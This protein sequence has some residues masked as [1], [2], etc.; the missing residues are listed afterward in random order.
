MN[1]AWDRAF[2]DCI[3][4]AAGRRG[5]QHMRLGLTALT[6]LPWAQDIGHAPDLDTLRSTIAD[7]DEPLVVLDLPAGM[8]PPDL[9]SI[10]HAWA[11][12]RHTQQHSLATGEDPV[13]SWPHHRRKQWRRAER[14]GM[15]AERTQDV[16]LLVQLHQA[17]RQ[18]KGI[19][20]DGT[21]LQHLLNHL[22]QEPDTHA[23]L[24]R[25]QD[26]EPIAGGL[27]HGAGDG[28]CIYGFGGQFRGQKAGISS[29]A[30]VLLIGTAMRHAAGQ[31]SRVFD[32]GGSQ[33]PGVDRF[34]AE[35]GA[36]AI[37]KWRA[38]RIRGVWRP[39]LRW[40]RPDLFPA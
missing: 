12:K 11:V 9:A 33:D 35:F 2:P 16:N 40:R 6:T 17:A 18:R 27:F 32:F 37:P 30:S 7:A 24:V 23:W 20:S 31:G 34:Y 8:S 25:G 14:E 13:E 10:R 38:V 3:H 36:E 28:R 26:G 15:T 22:L 4:D 19:P 5:T 1:T 39:I 29:R 21:A